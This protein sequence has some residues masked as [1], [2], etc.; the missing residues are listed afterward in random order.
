VQRED[1]FFATVFLGSGL[2]FLGMLLTAAALVGAI[3]MAFTAR[4]EELIDSA[5]FHFAR[6]AAYTLLQEQRPLRPPV[7]TRAD[8]YRAQ[9]QGGPRTVVA[10]SAGCRADELHL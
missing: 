3:L 5:T 8:A 1:R 9:A 10:R 4:P 7:R 2:L 6:A